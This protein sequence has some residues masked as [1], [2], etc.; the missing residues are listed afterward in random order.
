MTIEEIKSI[1]PHREPML[2]VDRIIERGEDKIVCEKDFH[3]DEFFFQGH[4]PDFPIVPGVILCECAAQS[5]AILLSKYI[6]TDSDTVPVLTRMKDIKFKRMVRPGETIRVSATLD[7]KMLN[8]Y[9]LS[10]TVMVGDELAARV[11]YAC[12]LAPRGK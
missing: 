1:L 5:G 8:A 12:S 3:A 2:L 4:Y 10:A 9:F 11:S 7:D 6:E